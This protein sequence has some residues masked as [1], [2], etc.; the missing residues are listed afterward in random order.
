MCAHPFDANRVK[1]PR[2]SQGANLSS[3]SLLKYNAMKQ[4]SSGRLLEE[5][6]YPCELFHWAATIDGIVNSS[7]N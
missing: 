7:S 5:R 1:S 4:G 6:A 2:I 3:C